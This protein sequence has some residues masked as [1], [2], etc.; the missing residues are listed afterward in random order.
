MIFGHFRK[1]F[2]DLKVCLASRLFE[3]DDDVKMK[4]DRLYP[5][6][7]RKTFLISQM[8]EMNLML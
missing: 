4:E 7:K 1:A 3:S 5:F 6:G 2:N 8:F